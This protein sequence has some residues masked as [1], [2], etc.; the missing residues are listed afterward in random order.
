MSIPG[1]AH[2]VVHRDPSRK[3]TAPA[4]LSE[5]VLGHRL[6][7]DQLPVLGTELDA[8][9]WPKTEHLADGLG[10]RDLALLRYDAFHTGKVGTLTSK[11]K[12]MGNGESNP[13]A[14]QPSASRW[15]VCDF[16]LIQNLSLNQPKVA[17]SM[18]LAMIERDLTPQLLAAARQF[19]AVTLTGPRQ[20]G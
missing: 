16:R 17:A 12:E 14:S 13:Q 6:R 7:P 19:P 11:S 4:P 10:N 18:P 8:R 3:A 15:L 9:S 2:V 5:D 20:S 1:V